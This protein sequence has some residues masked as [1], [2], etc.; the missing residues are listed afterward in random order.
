MIFRYAR[1]TT[2]LDNIRKF[3]TR[4]IGLDVIGTFEKHNNYN[5][6]FLGL[7]NEH[8]HLEF[9]TSNEAPNHKADEDDALVFYFKNHAEIEKRCDIAKLLNVKQV[10]SKNPYWNKHAITLLD[11]DGFRVILSLTKTS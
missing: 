3:Y 10:T 1:H 5:G 6:I 2:N 4:V 11:P 7:K 8:W 9:T